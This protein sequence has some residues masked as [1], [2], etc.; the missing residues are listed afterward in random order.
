M[1]S[2]VRDEDLWRAV[3]A[4][5]SSLPGH[6][7]DFMEPVH[8]VLQFWSSC[9]TALSCEA[10]RSRRVCVPCVV[11]SASLSR[12]AMPPRLC[13]W[14]VAA[15]EQVQHVM[16]R[17]RSLKIPCPGQACTIWW[18]LFAT[19]GVRDL[20]PWS[21]SNQLCC[22]RLGCVGRLLCSVPGWHQD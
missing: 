3:N 19:G 18:Y 1:W 14:R 11:R 17:R 4:V 2:L 8:Q 9:E 6:C 13:A 16:W 22:I 21:L 7:L 15:V 20:P 12:A 10:R 5:P